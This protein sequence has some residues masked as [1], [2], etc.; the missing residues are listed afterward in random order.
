MGRKNC[1]SPTHD[2]DPGELEDALVDAVEPRD[3]AVLVGEQRR[4]VEAR[5]AHAP[6]KIGRKREVFAEVRCVGEELFRDAADVD[7][8]A[9]ELVR[10]GDRHARAVPGADTA[11]T[12]AAGS[13]AYREEV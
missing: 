3:L 2:L 5:R 12:H 8:G 11:G 13:A 10:L 9:A 6:A 4:P 7:A 1:R